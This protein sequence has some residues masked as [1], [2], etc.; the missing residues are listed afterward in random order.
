MLTRLN[1]SHKVITIQAQGRI[2][3][4]GGQVI[5]DNGWHK[6]VVVGGY[7]Y[8]RLTG[9]GGM[10]LQDYTRLMIQGGAAPF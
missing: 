7:V 1:I 9:G 3:R 4:W 5:A 8:D 6:A 10:L 2:L